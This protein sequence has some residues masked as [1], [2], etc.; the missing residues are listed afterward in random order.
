MASVFVKTIPKINPTNTNLN[1]FIFLIYLFFK[2]KMV[3]LFIKGVCLQ[4][5]VYCCQFHS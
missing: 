5:N 3:S 4:Q 2:G 1:N